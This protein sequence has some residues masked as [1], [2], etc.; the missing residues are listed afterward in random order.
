MFWYDG[1]TAISNG[2]WTLLINV[3][4]GNCVH[5]C[6]VLVVVAIVPRLDVSNIGPGLCSKLT[7]KLHLYRLLLRHHSRAAPLGE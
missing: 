6:F 7:P 4:L 3:L 5:N 1:V 2:L